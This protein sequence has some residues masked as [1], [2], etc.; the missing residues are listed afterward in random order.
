MGAEV[1]IDSTPGDGTEVRS[2]TF[3]TPTTVIVGR[4]AECGIRV[5]AQERRVSRRHCAFDIAPPDVR[6]RDLGSRNGTYVNGVRLDADGP[7]TELTDGDEVR[8][9][10][11][12]LRVAVT[13]SAPD[14]G[15]GIPGYTLLRELGE[16]AQG[17][18]HL[19]RGPGSDELLAL[20]I[21]R[22][23]WA[24]PE[25]V[26]GFLRE[27]EATRALAHANIVRF[28]DAGSS[29][30]LLYLV[31]EFCDAGDLGSWVVA[32]DGPLPPDVAVSLTLQVLDGLA[33]AHDAP[34]PPVRDADGSLTPVRGLVHR[35]IKPPNLLLSGAG[36]HKTVKIAD[37]GLAKAFDRAG[38]SGLTHTGALGGSV[39]FMP[40]SQAV[41]Y[42]HVRPAVDVWATAACLYWMLTRATPRDFPRGVDPVVAVLREPVVPIGKRD[43]SVPPRLA[44][45]LDDV[46]ANDAPDDERTPSAGEF[47]R[48]LLNSV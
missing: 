19:A 25:A 40:R 28:R 4:A 26:S 23:E 3:Q 24:V 13:P 34:L 21:L 38:L 36:D 41:D 12:R 14:D 15:V 10:G 46:L 35:D 37:F 9:G 33:Y 44:A 6:V 47:A 39:G 17:T 8:A 20:K 43:A 16:G 11:L 1:R 30:E 32:Q 2:H 31:C 18:V 42:R 5:P 22:P 45:L 48:E 29:G 27:I 7:A